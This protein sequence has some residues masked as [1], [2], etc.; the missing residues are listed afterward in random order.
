MNCN[1][2]P[3]TL[4]IWIE[5]TLLCLPHSFPPYILNFQAWWSIADSVKTWHLVISQYNK[6][7]TLLFNRYIF[8]TLVKMA[9]T[10]TTLIQVTMLSRDAYS[11][12]SYIIAIAMYT[13]SLLWNVINLLQLVNSSR[14]LLHFGKKPWLE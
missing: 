5:A 1:F 12:A 8:K 4:K 13:G 10:P 2:K 11:H 3:S 14:E 9:P 6:L 7:A